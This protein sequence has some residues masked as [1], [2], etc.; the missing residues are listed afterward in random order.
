MFLVF[1]VFVGIGAES[2][3]GSWALQS[4]YSQEKA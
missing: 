4:G 1:L 3:G 2:A